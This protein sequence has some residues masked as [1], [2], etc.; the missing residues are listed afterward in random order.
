MGS[1]QLR[2]FE[3][4]AEMIAK[5][6]RLPDPPRRLC[7]IAAGVREFSHVVDAPEGIFGIA[8]WFPGSD[9]EATI[10]PSEGAFLRA[11]GDRFGCTA[12]LSGSAGRRRSDDRYPLCEAG[13]QYQPSCP[14]GSCDRTGNV[15]LVRRLQDR[16]RKRRPG[17]APDSSGALERRRTGTCGQPR[18]P[19][20]G[21]KRTHFGRRRRENS[22][23]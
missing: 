11:F 2:G 10:G 23:E 12:G 13:R 3:Q 21:R 17:Q 7:A 5:A 18:K 20:R 6:L 9:D 4:D 1:L 16:R 8:Q 22:C 15:D 19:R 14:V